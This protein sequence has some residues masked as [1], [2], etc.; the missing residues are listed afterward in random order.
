MARKSPASAE[1][2]SR[3]YVLHLLGIEYYMLVFVIPLDIQVI[4]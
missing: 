4:S 1:P 2:K 3:K